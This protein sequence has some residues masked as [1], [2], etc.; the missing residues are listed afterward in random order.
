MTVAILRLHDL[1]GRDLRI[2][3]IDSGVWF[4]GRG[5]RIV[6]IDLCEPESV[7]K[8]TL[9]IVGGLLSESELG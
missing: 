9:C 1:Y 7:D 5:V 3:H 6:E 8:I 4:S 2:F